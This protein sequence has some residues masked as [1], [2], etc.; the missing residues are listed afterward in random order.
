MSRTQI[1]FRGSSIQASSVSSGRVVSETPVDSGA[2][3]S[4][5]YV[6]ISGATASAAAPTSSPF[7]FT[8]PG[9][10][11][12]QGASTVNTGAFSTIAHVSK[13]VSGTYVMTA[14]AAPTVDGVSGVFT[15]SVSS[16]VLVLARGT[17]TGP[18]TISVTARKL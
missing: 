9:T 6:Y 12:L 5:T 7:T 3:A 15:P 16:G 18:D 14:T 11:I 4:Y 17:A 10:Y 13:N 8:Q 2:I 1:D